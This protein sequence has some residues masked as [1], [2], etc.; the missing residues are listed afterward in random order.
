MSPDAPTI[1]ATGVALAAVNVWL[2]ACLSSDIRHR[3]TRLEDRLLPVEK[4]QARASGLLRGLGLTAR[5]DRRIAESAADRRAFRTEMQHLAEP[6][7]HLEGR[8]DA[9]VG[10]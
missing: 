7:S 3:Q 4:E 1:I 6:Q 8:L 5:L 9:T 2:F 10:E